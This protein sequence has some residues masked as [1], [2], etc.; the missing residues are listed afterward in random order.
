MAR[1]GGSGAA[2]L[3]RNL[4]VLTLVSLTQDAASEL[5][6][7]LLPLF[8]TGVLAAPPVVLGVVEGAAEAAA[9]VSKYVAGRWSD[10]RSRRP[11]VTSGYGLAALGKVLVAAS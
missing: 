6:Y 2:W 9:G 7:P 4:V 11:F 10:N 8:I 3:T 1:R 5:L